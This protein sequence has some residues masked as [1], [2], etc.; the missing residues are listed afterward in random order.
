MQA[1]HSLQICSRGFFCDDI[2]FASKSTIKNDS[3]RLFFGLQRDLGYRSPPR[4]HPW[5]NSLSWTTAPFEVNDGALESLGCDES[6]KIISIVAFNFVDELWG[7]TW[8]DLTQNLKKKIFDWMYLL[9]Y[10]AVFNSDNFPRF[11]K[12]RAF[13]CTPN[14]LQRICSSWDRIFLQGGI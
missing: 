13:Q 7:K 4:Y 5:I 8:R 12:T 2:I 14:D 11:Y 1:F 9:K 10:E 6:G 3:K